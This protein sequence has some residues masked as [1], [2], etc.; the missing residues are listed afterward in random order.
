MF[1]GTSAEGVYRTPGPTAYLKDIRYEG[2]ERRKTESMHDQS[3]T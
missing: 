2:A 3:Q 1:Y